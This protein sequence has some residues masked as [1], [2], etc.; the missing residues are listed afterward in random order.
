M[1]L[2]I[3]DLE[4]MLTRRGYTWKAYDQDNIGFSRVQWLVSSRET[5]SDIL[6]I[7]P[8]LK[9]GQTAILLKNRVWQIFGMM[10][11]E[12]LTFVQEQLAR[13]NALEEQLISHI[14][15]KGSLRDFL[16][17]ASCF[18]D[19]PVFVVV[20][21]QRFLDCSANAEA[22]LPQI[23]VFLQSYN[24]LSVLSHPLSER[25][26]DFSDSIPGVENH[27]LSSRFWNASQYF[28]RFF[29]YHYRSTI[30]EGVL[31]RIEEVT[32]YLNTLLMVNDQSYYATSYISSVLKDI[33]EGTFTNWPR[34]RQELS[35]V[36][37]Q[38]SQ[39]LRMISMGNVDEPSLLTELRDSLLSLNLPLYCFSEGKNLILLCNE[40]HQ[41]ELLTIL[42]HVISSQ[43]FPVN[44]GVSGFFHDLEK[45]PLYLRQ[46]RF[47]LEY[48]RQNGPAVQQIES[49]VSNAFQKLLTNIPDSDCWI[50]PDLML[51]ER[52][53]RENGTQ[54]FASVTTFLLENCNYEKC[55]EKM[56]LHPNTIRYRIRRVTE[57]MQS[58]LYD[59]VNH[60][61]LL[62]S[63]MLLRN[64]APGTL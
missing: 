15:Q 51:L 34:L 36:N 29:V 19:C 30:D 39:D 45:I 55:A 12:L 56:G 33:C 35:A 49:I 48:A 6:Y 20:S 3:K 46:S 13:F 63:L 54:L 41:P 38:E 1:I 58:N 2:F 37:W 10:P 18:F 52:Y 27:I 11:E 59:P 64:N 16:T 22:S 50:H 53:D 7:C 21:G 17:T 8:E 44:I 32:K 4:V 61:N 24:Q 47:A 42:Y 9:R 14:L 31:Y 43:E 5:E 25:I 28:G 60:E 40:S 62:V 57:L 23:Q 26:E